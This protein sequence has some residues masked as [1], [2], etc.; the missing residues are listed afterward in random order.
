M[1]TYF[2]VADHHMDFVCNGVPSHLEKGMKVKD[3]LIKYMLEKHPNLISKVGDVK[4]VE[5]PIIKAPV[6]KVIEPVIKKIDVELESLSNFFSEIAQDTPESSPVDDVDSKELESLDE[7]DA[8]LEN[9]SPKIKKFDLNTLKTFKNIKFMSREE[10]DSVCS[11]LNVEYTSKV[12]TAKAI[13][14]ILNVAV[15]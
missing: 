8:I 12:A 3:R 6:N 15:K 1:D 13:A 4:P 14:K 7:I 2:Y 11:Q 9:A 10:M 5:V